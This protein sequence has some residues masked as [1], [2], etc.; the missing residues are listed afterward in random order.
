MTH[1]RFD[2]A[3]LLHAGLIALLLGLQFVAPAYHHLALARIMVLATFAAGYN[4]L[5]GYTGLLSL[6]H[7]M[8]FAAGLYGAGL[9]AFHLGWDAPAAFA[10][11]V[12]LGA[13]FSAGVGFVALR[14]SGVAFMIVTLMFSQAFHL[15]TFYF[16]AYT[17]GDEG[18]TIPANLRAF[19]LFGASFDLAD[20]AL[21]YNLSLALLAAAL[22]ASLAIV[23]GPVGRVFIAIRENEPRTAMLGYDTGRYK[24]LAF[25]ISG[26]ISAAAGAAYALL[27]GYVGATFASIQYSIYPLL[28]TLLG[29]A[30]TIA[31]PF[32][33]TT[34]MF[35]LVDVS[36]GYT[37]AHL[38]VVGLALLALVLFFPKGILGALRAR[39]FGWLP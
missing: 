33:G 6:G 21:R 32:V 10:A 13:A 16:G 22:A 4:L 23:R 37:N 28:W 8:L 17:R 36:S 7:A 26:T 38:L 9:T 5:F 25:V 15:A 29:G 31:G 20:P 2:K 12:V 3:V 34:L 35:Y 19:A 39:W 30:G 27:F 18:L 1:S 11:G 14:T 24:L